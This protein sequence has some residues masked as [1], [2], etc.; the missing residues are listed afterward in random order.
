MDQKYADVVNGERVR[1]LLAALTPS[2]S[3]IDGHSTRPA[4]PALRGRD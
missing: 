1:E 4:S 2:R 3:S